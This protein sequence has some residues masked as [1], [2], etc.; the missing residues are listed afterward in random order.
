MPHFCQDELVALLMVLP[1]IPYCF[2]R[3]R[4]WIFKRRH[5]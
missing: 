5:A 3:I 1:G 2:E 4:G